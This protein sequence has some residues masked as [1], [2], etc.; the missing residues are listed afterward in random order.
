MVYMKTLDGCKETTFEALAT[1]EVVAEVLDMRTLDVM[2]EM[3]GAP[4]LIMLTKGV[5]GCKDVASRMRILDARGMT[6]DFNTSSRLASGVD[7]CKDISSMMTIIGN[8]IWLGMLT[9]GVEGCNGIA[10]RM[11]MTVIGLRRKNNIV[12][13]CNDIASRTTVIDDEIWRKY[14]LRRCLIAGISSQDSVN[15]SVD[16]CKPFQDSINLMTVDFNAG[17]AR[18]PF[19]ESNAQIIEDSIN[20]GL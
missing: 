11:R 10:S 1:F 19:Q 13:G 20:L 12:D 4:E 5:D 7:G 6:I 18:K 2:K 9:K 14:S 15:Q 16:G 8:E 17:D 3:L